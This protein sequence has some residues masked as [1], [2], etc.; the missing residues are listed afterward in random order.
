M[1]GSIACW[2]ELFVLFIQNFPETFLLEQR[3]G[4]AE[5]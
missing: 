1:L 2:E 3:G 5:M 4:K